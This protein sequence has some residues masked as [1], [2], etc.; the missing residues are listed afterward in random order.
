MLGPG[1]GDLR[2]RLRPG[3]RRDQRPEGD[4][5]A[6]HPDHRRRQRP[7]GHGRLRGQYGDELNF[8]FLEPDESP[9]GCGG[10]GALRAEGRD[11]ATLRF[12]LYAAT[13]QMRDAGQARVDLL[14]ALRGVGLDRIVCFPT[15]WSPTLEA[16]A[17]FADDCRAAGARRRSRRERRLA[18][19]SAPARAPSG[20]SGRRGA[21]ARSGTRRARPAGP[22]GPGRSGANRSARRTRPPR[23]RVAVAS[24]TSQASSSASS[25]IAVRERDAVTRARG[26]RLT[27]S[28]A[29]SGSRKTTTE[30]RRGQRSTV[31]S[32]SSQSPASM[33]GACSPR[34]RRPATARGARAEARR[35]TRPRRSAGPRVA[36]R[37][38]EWRS[39]G[40][41]GDPRLARRRRSPSRRRRSRRSCRGASWRRPGRSTP[42]P[43]RPACWRSRRARAG[44]GPSR[45]ARA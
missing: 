17:A 18:S 30:P 11:P 23:P 10:P 43:S 27:A 39:A 2:G 16:Q 5:A 15:R 6:A 33:A 25:R 24:L 34:P 21:T 40:S 28:A 45:G 36:S 29:P 37:A 44:S 4:P 26:D 19:G 13:R 38:A 35:P 8:V 12:S 20:R 22:A 7:A 42:S 31:G 41:A 14:G 32:T 3:P 1:P 9:S